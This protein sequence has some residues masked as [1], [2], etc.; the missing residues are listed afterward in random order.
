MAASG[1]S[2][3]QDRPLLISCF[4]GG[5]IRTVYPAL[6]GIDCVFFSNN[7]QCRAL[8][9]SRGWQFRLVESLPLISDYRAC[10]VQAKYIKFLQFFPEFP[11]Y[12]D[13]TRIVY[14]DH[15]IFFRKSDLDWLQFHHRPDKSALVLRHLV[16]DRTIWGEVEAA[17]AQSRYAQAMPQAIEWLKTLERDQQ[18]DL[19]QLVDATTLISY[20]EPCRIMPLLDEIYRQTLR[21]GQPECQII[22]SA[23]A[24]LYPDCILRFPWRDLDP[25]WRVPYR[26]RREYLSALK[27]RVLNRIKRLVSADSP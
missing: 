26:S 18:V 21:L 8:V 3:T 27:S 9:V 22:W 17:S 19:D 20:R 16:T 11:E 7:E 14:F 12:A 23:L 2:R 25:L 6:R 5:Q 10:S 24:Q 13:R 15:T 1:V 4:F